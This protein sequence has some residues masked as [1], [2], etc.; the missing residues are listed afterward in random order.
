MSNLVKE[1]YGAQMIEF[2][3]YEIKYSANKLEVVRTC[4]KRENTPDHILSDYIEPI[5]QKFNKNYKDSLGNDEFS[6]YLAFENITQLCNL[7]RYHWNQDILFDERTIHNRDA[8]FSGAKRQIPIS[9]NKVILPIVHFSFFDILPIDVTSAYFKTL[10]EVLLS[11]GKTHKDA[12]ELV[13]LSVWRC[14]NII[15]CSIWN[16]YLPYY[17]SKQEK[18]TPCSELTKGNEGGE[19]EEPTAEYPY[20]EFYDRLRYILA[21]ISHNTKMKYYSLNVAHEY[22]DFDA[23]RLTQDY[24]QGDH[25]KG[26]APF[27]YHS[28]YRMRSM[29]LKIISESSADSKTVSIDSC[30][31]KLFP[32][33][34]WRFLLLDDKCF[35]SS[36]SEDQDKGYLKPETSEVSKSTI[37]KDRLA[38]LGFN[39]RVIPVKSIDS[40]KEPEQLEL[41]DVIP[42]NETNIDIELVCVKDIDTAKALMKRMEFDIILLDYFLNNTDKKEYGHELLSWL[43]DEL[44]VNNTSDSEHYTLGAKS[45]GGVR[46]IKV[47]PNERYFFIFISAFSSAVT[48]RLRES[49]LQRSAKRW[50][51]G[52][53][54]CPTNTPYLFLY[55]L[56]MLMKKRLGDSGV[57]KDINPR[58]ELF[59]KDIFESENV[60]LVA[61]KQFSESLKRLYSYKSIMKDFHLPSRPLYNQSY[62]QTSIFDSEGS[63]LMTSFIEQNPFYGGILEHLTQLL[64]LTSF[65]TVRQWE[66]MWEEYRFISSILGKTFPKVEAYIKTL[67]GC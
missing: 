17:L 54:A 28:E 13:H 67:K 4:N 22:A 60:R 21:E 41:M 36:K 51:I 63:V 52:E 55:Q 23:R 49:G 45:P 56:V 30:K 58:I 34:K 24:V 62:R 26:V 39:V 61:Q 33:L 12:K 50:H 16:Y 32:K 20:N 7:E 27:L 25:G 3:V 19:E 5:I 57:D 44:G 37:L 59:L 18:P 2:P 15:D 47:G 43:N 38:M 14:R 1:E 48:E 42:H 31:E 53:G 40:N 9:D 11:L 8:S 35:G 65:G 29:I 6:F 10:P 46:N 64:Y 66:E